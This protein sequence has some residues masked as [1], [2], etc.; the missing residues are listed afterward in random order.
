MEERE[1]NN[2]TKGI[3]K[4]KLDLERDFF[5]FFIFSF[6]SLLLFIAKD[7]P[8]LLRVVFPSTDLV[9]SPSQ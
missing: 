8:R 1:E 2:L 3:R 6:Y 9:H 5:L 7:F 4:G